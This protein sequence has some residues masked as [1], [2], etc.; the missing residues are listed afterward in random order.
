MVDLTRHRNKSGRWVVRARLLDLVPGRSKKAYADWLA[1][2]GPAFREGIGVAALDPFGGYKSA[3]DDQ[4]ADAVAVLDAFHVVKLGT[5][6]VDE[7]RR[8]VQQDTTGHRGRK[9]DPLFGIQ[10]M[11]R[12]GAENLT[13]RQ[14]QRLQEAINADERHE[15][16]YIA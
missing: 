3:I 12:A 1:E 8:R 4:F 9:G 15:E 2:R 10:T 5:A 14:L 7:V 16:V 6:V 11:L 13:D